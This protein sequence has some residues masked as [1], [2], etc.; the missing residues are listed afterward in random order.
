M[1][2]GGRGCSTP[3]L[4]QFITFKNCAIGYYI[5]I[6]VVEQKIISGFKNRARRDHWKLNCISGCGQTVKRAKIRTFCS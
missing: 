1:G 6:Y 4:P 2:G 5:L 3:P